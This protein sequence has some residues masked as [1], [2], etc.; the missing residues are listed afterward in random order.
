MS[1]QS[2]LKTFIAGSARSPL[3]EHD[4]LA[5]GLPLSSDPA[6]TVLEA[7]VTTNLLQKAASPLPLRRRLFAATPL[8]KI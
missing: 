4:S 2:V 7:L 3:S 1:W 8:L 5:L 6:Q